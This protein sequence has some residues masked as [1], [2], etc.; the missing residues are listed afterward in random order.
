MRCLRGLHSGGDKACVRRVDIVGTKP[1]MAQMDFAVVRRAQLQL[2]VG[3]GVNDHGKVLR[4]ELRHH[5]EGTGQPF[6]VVVEVRHGQGDVVEH[7]RCLSRQLLSAARPSSSAASRAS[8]SSMSGPASTCR[9]GRSRSSQRGNHQLRSPSSSI[10]A[11]HQH[12][13]DDGRVD[14]DRGGEAEA[15]QLERRLGRRG[16]SRR[17]R[18]TM[19]SA[20]AVI[21]RAVAARPS[22]TASRVVAGAVVLLADPREQE[23]LVVHRQAEQDREHHHRDE[24]RDRA[25]SC[26][27]RSALPN[28]PHWNTATTTP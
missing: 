27:R 15:E 1:E 6:D 3:A 24:R 25:R 10:V 23:H 17:T 14:E 22:A 4:T 9:R 7:R 21:T 19:I 13:P 5:A 18:V 16:R 11:G 12:H 20:A 26:R 8:S 28:Q 2:E